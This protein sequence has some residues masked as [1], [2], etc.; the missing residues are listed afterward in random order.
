M[1]NKL[2]NLFNKNYQSSII[3]SIQIAL[4]SQTNGIGIKFKKHDA[5]YS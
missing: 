1:E 3:I 4:S 5:M 2:V